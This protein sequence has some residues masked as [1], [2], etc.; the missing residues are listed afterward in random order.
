VFQAMDLLIARSGRCS[1]AQ[2]A[3]EKRSYDLETF[4]D[5]TPFRDR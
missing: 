4:F 1:R 5:G 3:F 2:A